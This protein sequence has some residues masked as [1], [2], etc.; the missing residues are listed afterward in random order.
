MDNTGIS[1]VAEKPLIT[2]TKCNLHQTRIKMVNGEGNILSPVFLIGEAPG[3]NEDIAGL[4]FQGQ[5]GSILNKLLSQTS[6]NRSDFYI[7]NIVKC[8]PILIRNNKKENRQPTA[9]EIE[10]CRDNIE[11]TIA[12]GKPKAIVAMGNV[13]L[14]Y[15]LDDRSKSITK[16]RGQFIWSDKYQCYV[17]PVFHPAAILRQFEYYNVTANDFARLKQFIDNNYALPKPATTVY[18]LVDTPELLN[19]RFYH[20]FKYKLERNYRICNTI[21]ME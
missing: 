12:T 17:Y 16:M 2:C 9:E 3:Q 15:L 14:K 1:Q 10:L 11:Q 8:R 13:A 7:D 18:T 4:P 5:A 20:M 19:Q 21:S 6:L